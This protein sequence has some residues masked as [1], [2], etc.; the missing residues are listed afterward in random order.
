MPKYLEI[1]KYIFKLHVVK[2]D[3]PREILKYF[4][5]NENKKY[6]LKF[7]GCRWISVQLWIT[8]GHIA[9][10]GASVPIGVK[11][12]PQGGLGRLHRALK[13]FEGLGFGNAVRRCSWFINARV[14]PRSHEM[15]AGGWLKST[16][17]KH[18]HNSWYTQVTQYLFL[19]WP[20]SICSAAPLWWWAA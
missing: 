8:G 6:N 20:W 7:R 18:H 16:E 4:E 3:I 11:D 10:G 17:K 14:S 2:E 13:H 5:L 15:S 12:W 1:T 19:S 9:V